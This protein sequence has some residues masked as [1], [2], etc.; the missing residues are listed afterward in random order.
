MLPV[1]RRFSVVSGRRR[2][3]NALAEAFR[4]AVQALDANAAREGVLLT[5]RGRQPLG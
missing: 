2:G 3:P 5:L 1:G 4:S